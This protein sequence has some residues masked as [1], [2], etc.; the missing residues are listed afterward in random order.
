MIT[1]NTVG[2]VCTDPE[3]KQVGETNLATYRIAVK[4]AGE[5][6][7][8]SAN[9]GRLDGFF[10][11]ES[12]G[13]NADFVNNYVKK[14]SVLQITGTLRHRSWDDKESGKKR[15][16]ITLV[17][18]Q[19]SFTPNQPARDGNSSEHQAVGAVVSPAAAQTEDPFDV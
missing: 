14:G 7:T 18:D 11:V 13:R 17:A 9:P 2:R 6:S 8:D 1:F 4:A 5:K 16:A 3:I 10:S 15:E 19:I 12:W